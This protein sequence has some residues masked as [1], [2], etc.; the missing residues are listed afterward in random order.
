MHI[1]LKD[2]Y[3]SSVSLKKRNNKQKTKR[4][5]DLKYNASYDTNSLKEFVITFNIKVTDS[6]KF[7]LNIEYIAE[8]MTSDNVDDEFINS[9]FANINSPAIAYPFLR[10]FVSI[11]ALNAG[12]GSIYLP[13][14]NFVEFSK[15]Q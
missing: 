1:S 7:D 2:T 6:S 14:I 8:F 9:D 13:A 15:K 11:L 12:Y 4:V 5:F 10:S 3:A